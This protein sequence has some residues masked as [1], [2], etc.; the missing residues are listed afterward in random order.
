MFEFLPFERPR[1][2]IDVVHGGD[3]GERKVMTD[4]TPP[5]WPLAFSVTPVICPPSIPLSYYGSHGDRIHNPWLLFN[6]K[7]PIIFLSMWDEIMHSVKNTRFSVL[8]SE[9]IS[10][11]GL[12][13]NVILATMNSLKK[14][15]GIF[16]VNGTREISYVND[17]RCGRNSLVVTSGENES[18]LKMAF[19]IKTNPKM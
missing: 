13:G 19:V 12:Q 18:R 3:D 9:I 16:L 10:K 2:F 15:L 5:P 6:P 4:V 1:V 14:V 17:R 11:S 7:W 8:N